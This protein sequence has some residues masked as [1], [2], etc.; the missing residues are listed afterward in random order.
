MMGDFEGIYSQI[1][2][3]KDRIQDTSEHIDMDDAYILAMTEMFVIQFD[4]FLEDILLIKLAEGDDYVVEVSIHEYQQYRQILLRLIYEIGIQVTEKYP[5]IAQ[6]FFGDRVEAIKDQ[7][8][9]ISLRGKVMEIYNLQAEYYL[10]YE[11]IKGGIKTHQLENSLKTFEGLTTDYE[12]LYMSGMKSLGTKFK[13]GRLVF[14]IM[15]VHSHGIPMSID[16]IANASKKD[17]RTIRKGI[18]QMMEG[19]GHLIRVVQ[20]GVLDTYYIPEPFRRLHVR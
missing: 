3:M 8:K 12:K 7:I 4:E 17:K 1:R 13:T 16:E 11:L 14:D 20:R 2:D 10:L 6:T 15:V 9:G 18:E 5:N 19:A